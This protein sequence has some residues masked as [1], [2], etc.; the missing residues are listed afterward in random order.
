[1][2]STSASSS[3]A[4]PLAGHD[5][6]WQEREHAGRATSSTLGFT[7]AKVSTLSGSS[8]DSVRVQAKIIKD[9]I[10]TIQQTLADT[11]NQ[12]GRRHPV[13]PQRRRQRHVHVPDG[14]QQDGDAGQVE[15]AMAATGHTDAKVTVD[16]QN[17]TVA[18]DKLPTSPLTDVAQKLADY[19]GVNVSRS[20]SAP[21]APPGARRSAARRCRRSS[22]S[23]SSSRCT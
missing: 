21:S 9:P 6:R 23:S 19:A 18:F 5:G 10:R 11:S 15:K 8:G 1:V 13:R 14:R 20:A 2:A 12:R 7:D 22:S 16:G 17:V 3:R 4:A